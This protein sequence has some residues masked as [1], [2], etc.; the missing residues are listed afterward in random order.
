MN[1]GFQSQGA[2]VLA[3]CDSNVA[4]PS[5]EEEGDSPNFAWRL[6]ME[7]REYSSSDGEDLGSSSGGAAAASEDEEEE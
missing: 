2:G 3:S 4:C 6:A 5:S 7:M 1:K